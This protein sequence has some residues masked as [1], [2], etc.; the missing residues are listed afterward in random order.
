MAGPSLITSRIEAGAALVRELD[1]RNLQP[2]TA[3]WVFLVDR[4]RWKLILQFDASHEKFPTLVEIAGL[5]ADR[6]AISRELSMADVS[7]A[8]PTDAI[9][10]ALKALVHTGP[11]LDHVR[12]GPVSAN[13]IYVEDG[14]VYRALDPLIPALS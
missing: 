8:R 1:A 14:L 3:A 12:I 2:E 6:D 10:G 5:I 13:G 9:V 4:E 7:V 11:G